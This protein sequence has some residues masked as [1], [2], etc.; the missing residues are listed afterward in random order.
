MGETERDR[1]RGMRDGVEWRERERERWLGKEG[2]GGREVEGWSGER[3]R[4]D[5]T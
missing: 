3:E 1:E 5:V 4:W 2:G